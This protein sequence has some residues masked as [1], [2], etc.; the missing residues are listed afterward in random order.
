M[1]YSTS[2]LLFGIFK[3]SIHLRDIWACK[4]VE[5][6]L[7]LEIRLCTEWFLFLS[8]LLSKSLTFS[9]LCWNFAVSLTSYFLHIFAIITL[10]LGFGLQRE[11]IAHHQLHRCWGSVGNTIGEIL[12]GQHDWDDFLALFYIDHK[13]IGLSKIGLFLYEWRNTLAVCSLLW[14]AWRL[15]SW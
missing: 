11:A 5:F 12:A 2:G 9:S 15:S 13:V 6:E 8:I 3:S 14:I 7:F 1:R 4:L 10:V